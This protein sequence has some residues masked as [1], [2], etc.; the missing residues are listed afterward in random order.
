[1]EIPI[2]EFQARVARVQ[3]LLRQHKLDAALVYYDELRSANGVYLSNWV[4]QFESGA[5]LVPLEGE[6]C[7][8]GGPESEPFA[9]ADA[10]IKKTYNVPVFMVPEEEYPYARIL[11]MGQ[12]MAEAL[13]GRPL[14]RLGIVG[15]EVMPHAL[16]AELTQQLSDVELADITEP[17]EQLRWFKSAAEVACIREAFG[18]ATQA[19][20][21]M[22]E[23]IKAGNSEQ[24]VGAAGEAKARALGCAGFGYRTIV[25]SGPRAGS[26]V[27][28]PTA[29]RMADGELVMFSIS[30]RVN[31]YAS[32]VGDTTVVGG[33]ASDAQKRLLSHMAH[34][35]DIA[36]KQ[37]VIGRTGVEMDAPI[38]AYLLECGY[39]PYML[40]PYIHTVGLFEAEGPFFGPRSHVT[41]QPHMT[42]CIDVSLFGMPDLHGA[43]FESGFAITED[44]VVPFAPEIDALI[45]SHR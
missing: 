32:S 20:A 16:H 37:L 22:S 34:A 12:V 19:L 28:T 4:P 13:G 9:K 38:R 18:M 41:L 40:V 21:P 36:C 1:M 29:R 39:A 5:V 42:V 26:V 10:A 2:S 3:A 25:G 23:Q 30:P 44:G 45:L 8:L 31:G 27:P 33:K 7:I 14:R 24:Q 43:R 17:Y 6:P 35:Y 11:S 15:L